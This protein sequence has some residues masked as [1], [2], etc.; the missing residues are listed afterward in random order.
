MALNKRSI[1]TCFL[2]SYWLN[3]NII[4]R[5][6][7]VILG[8]ITFLKTKAQYNRKTWLCK[9]EAD[10]MEYQRSSG[11]RH[12]LD[13]R[14]DYILIRSIYSLFLILLIKWNSSWTFVKSKMLKKCRHKGG[15]K[16]LKQSK[17]RKHIEAHCT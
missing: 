5:A 17:Q 9:P 7:T 6:P 12:F 11:F 2:I 14:E 10:Q 4:A 1:G 16:I 8:P 15:K 13:T 3:V